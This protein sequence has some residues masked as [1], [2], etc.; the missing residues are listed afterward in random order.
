MQYLS[1]L[2]FVPMLTGKAQPANQFL[3]VA[4]PLSEFSEQW[5]DPRYEFC[6]TAATATYMTRQE[7]DVI[8]ILN[9][10][11]T[12]PQLFCETVVKKYAAFSLNDEL[13]ATTWYK[14]LV[15]TMTIMKPVN[16]LEPNQDCYNSAQCHAYN[17]GVKGY[18]GHERQGA[19]D[20]KA[21]Y[22]GECCD[23]SNDAAID[24]VMS[25][26]IDENVPLLGHREICFGAYK[27]IGVS[28]Q[29]HKKWVYNTVLDFHY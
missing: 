17:S 22:D 20:A 24:I 10:A 11:R 12:S 7:K 14:S 27:F 6:N 28:T 8:W 13:E 19:C 21:F 15:K 16:M 3:T 26:L 23:Y 1:L 5:N 18:E 9:M 29:P 4:S 2:L 25:L